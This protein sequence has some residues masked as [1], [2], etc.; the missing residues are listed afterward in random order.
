MNHW[1]NLDE[2][3]LSTVTDLKCYCTQGQICLDDLY[4]MAAGKSAGCI[5]NLKAIG[6]LQAR[7]AEIQVNQSQIK[8][9]E[10]R[11]KMREFGIAI[12]GLSVSC[13]RCKVP[14]IDWTACFA[15]TCTKCGTNFCGWC[16][17]WS[18]ADVHQ[19][20]QE[21]HGALFGSTE[22]MVTVMK[23]HLS[24]LIVEKLLS[25]PHKT[26][27]YAYNYILNYLESAE[28]LDTVRVKLQQHGYKLNLLVLGSWSNSDTRFSLYEDPEIRFL[29][30]IAL[31]RR[32]PTLLW[33]DDKRY[34]PPSR[35]YAIFQPSLSE[36]PGFQMT[37][38]RAHSSLSVFHVCQAS[39]HGDKPLNLVLLR[40]LESSL[41]SVQEQA[42]VMLSALETELC[43]QMLDDGV[44]Y[45][46]FYNKSGEP[47]APQDRTYRK[48]QA[49]PQA[50]Y[51]VIY[52]NRTVGLLCPLFA[53]SGY[54]RIRAVG[55]ACPYFQTKKGCKTVGPCK[56]EHV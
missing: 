10:L 25:L 6:V 22:Q 43:L 36:V 30:S 34:N 4:Q 23:G 7:Y 2:T 51:L 27:V 52:P 19:H 45:V 31:Q 16:L 37:V 14:F 39:E 55:S 8:E 9:D 24:D 47:V 3:C 41:D 11:F 12:E 32:A 29:T 15:V 20:V 35:T 42:A 33:F 54:V 46:H 49:K 40:S 56:Y 5:S 18:Q 1:L 13:P 50:E 17:K 48:N 44:P 21:A 38:E 53:E 28:I 26:I